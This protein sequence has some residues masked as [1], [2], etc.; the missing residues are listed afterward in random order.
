MFAFYGRNKI[1]LAFIVT[2]YLAEMGAQLWIIVIT[3]P[4]IEIIPTPLPSTLDAN[5]CL[6]LN[7]PSLLPNIWYG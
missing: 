5:A 3:V 1:L 7:I 6:A 4:S 2:L